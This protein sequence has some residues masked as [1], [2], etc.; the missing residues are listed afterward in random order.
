MALKCDR[1]RFLGASAATL[2]GAPGLAPLHAQG[3]Q[4][5]MRVGMFVSVGKDAEPAIRQVQELG[6]ADC[7]VYTNDLDLE[8]ADRLARRAR[9][10]RSESCG[11][12]LPGPRTDGLGFL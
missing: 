1:R 3:G 7:E 12:L 8:S 2:M 4:G 5:K 10:A 6:F 11:S 9:S